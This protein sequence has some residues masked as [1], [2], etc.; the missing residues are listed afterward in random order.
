MTNKKTK[1]HKTHTTHKAHKNHKASEKKEE[2]VSDKVS[3][4]PMAENIALIAVVFLVVGLLVGALVSYGAFMMNAPAEPVII[5]GGTNI[6]SNSVDTEALKL[7][8]QEYVNT[9]MLPAEVTFTVLDVNQQEDGIFELS[10]TISQ[11]GEVVEEGVIHSTKNKL[12]VGAVVDLDETVEVPEPQEP[13]AGVEVSKEEVPNAEL[14]I[15]SYCPYGVTALAPFADV[16]V[17]VGDKANF[18]AIMYYDGHGAYE[19]QQNKIQACIQ[20]LDKESYWAYAAKFVSDIYPKCGASKDVTC[21]LDESTLLMNSLGIDSNAVLECV[22]NEGEALI[23]A[24]SAKAQALGVTGSPT[25]VVNGTKVT[26]VA[27]TANGFLGAV[28]SGFLQ[29]PEACSTVLNDEAGAVAGS[30]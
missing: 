19:T 25:L 23:A 14:Y 6:G 28:C 2:H 11:E 1:T 30:C 18:S 26:N 24:H 17:T 15:W 22:E 13:S 7:K 8:V 9:N 20:E 12:I 3:T 4:S 29:T 27:R 16:A 10:Y 5:D 21:D